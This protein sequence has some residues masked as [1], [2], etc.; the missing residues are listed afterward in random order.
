MTLNTFS[1]KICFKIFSTGQNYL[2]DSQSASGIRTSILTSDAEMMMNSTELFAQPQLDE[3]SQNKISALESQLSDSKTSPQR[4]LI[5]D[6][7]QEEARLE[8]LVSGVSINERRTQ[9]HSKSSSPDH[10][11]VER[12]TPVS[13]ET[14][15]KQQEEKQDH[16]QQSNPMAQSSFSEEEVVYSEYCGLRLRLSRCYLNSQSG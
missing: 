15:A 8:R 10:E 7:D 2:V 12:M 9:R 11:H 6:A 13:P 4:S 5:S 14:P 1:H 16:S 3:Q